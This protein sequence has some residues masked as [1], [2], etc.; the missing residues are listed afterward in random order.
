[1][2]DDM[3]KMQSTIDLLE[4]ELRASDRTIDELKKEIEELTKK[5]AAY[6]CIMFFLGLVAFVL[7]YALMN[8]L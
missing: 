4:S 6:G 2:S 7:G 5:N 8:A 3:D 1:M